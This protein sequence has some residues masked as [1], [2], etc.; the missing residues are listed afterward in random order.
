MKPGLRV[1]AVVIGL[2]AVSLAVSLAW[3]TLVDAA[4][5]R[6]AQE[7]FAPDGLQLQSFTESGSLFN[8]HGVVEFRGQEAKRPVLIRVELHRLA[9]FLPWS[10]TDVQRGAVAEPEAAPGPP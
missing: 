2:V 10:V 4:R 8:R 7:G 5:A 3:P 6:M 9:Y 1:V